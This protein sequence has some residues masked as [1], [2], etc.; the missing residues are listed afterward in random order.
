MSSEQSGTKGGDGYEPPV[1]EIDVHDGTIGAVRKVSGGPV[2]IRICERAAV[3]SPG[4]AEGHG[5]P[6]DPAT[7]F[8]EYTL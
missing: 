5:G 8:L 3:P 2:H 7:K 1:I 6:R 4:G